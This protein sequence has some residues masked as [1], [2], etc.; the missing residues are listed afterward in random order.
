M[1]WM[2]AKPA[3]QVSAPNGGEAAIERLASAADGSYRVRLNVRMVTDD[4]MPI[5]NREACQDLI[6]KCEQTR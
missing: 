3:V 4:R 1:V 6:C 2:R 5:L